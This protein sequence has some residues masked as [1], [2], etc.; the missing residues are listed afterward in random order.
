MLTQRSAGTGEEKLFNKNLNI[1]CNCPLSDRNQNQNALSNK[2]YCFIRVLS[3]RRVD[4]FT[5]SEYAVV[6]V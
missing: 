6:V 5:T 2:I 1:D 4:T 3:H